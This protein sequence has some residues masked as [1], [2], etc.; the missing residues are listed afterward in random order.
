MAARA[1]GLADGGNASLRVQGSSLLA[2]AIPAGAFY[3]LLL[4]PRACLTISTCSCR[5][6]SFFQVGSLSLS[7]ASRGGGGGE[8]GLG[9]GAVELGSVSVVCHLERLECRPARASCSK[10]QCA[11]RN[12]PFFSSHIA[13]RLLMTVSK[14]PVCYLSDWA[15][16]IR[17]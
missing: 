10:S 16:A 7:H 6:L 5:P 11:S 2:T 1:G 13:D 3:V 8:G 4:T 9:L 17:S 12:E 14:G 15:A